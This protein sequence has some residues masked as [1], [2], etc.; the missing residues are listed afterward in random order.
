[1]LFGGGFG[2]PLLAEMAHRPGVSIHVIPAGTGAHIGLLGAFA[3]A[4]GE[5]DSAG[6]VYMESPDEGHTTRNPATV[7]KISLTFDALH[8]EAL[9]RGASKG[10]LVKA[11]EGHGRE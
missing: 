8:S 2:E 4:N 1:L 5:G 7:T 6:T 11:A 9:P 10:L 3:I